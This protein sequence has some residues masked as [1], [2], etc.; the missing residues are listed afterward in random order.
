MLCINFPSTTIKNC[1]CNY[2]IIRRIVP[3]IASNAGL[4]SGLSSQHF[5]ISS[6]RSSGQSRL[7]VAGRNGGTSLAATLAIISKIV[8]YSITGKGTLYTMKTRG[9][10]E[11]VPSGS[12]NCLAALKG[13]PLT[14]ISSKM[15]PK[16][17]TSPFWVAGVPGMTVSGR[18]SGATHSNS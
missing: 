18:S 13:P 11:L 3:L 1:Q 10:E 2:F 7:P 16:L 8:L 4:S 9:I 6:S 5:S 15:I 14:T 12:R 17:Y